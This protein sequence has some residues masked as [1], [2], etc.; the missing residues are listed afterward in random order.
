MVGAVDIGGT[1]IAV[2]LVDELGQIAAKQEFP[3]SVDRGFEFAMARV[4]EALKAQIASTH[5]QLEGIGMG[6]TGPVDPISGVLGN[7]NLLPGW[8]EMN[9][10]ELLSREFDISTAIENDADAVAIG[11]AM[12]GVGKG[13]QSLVCITVGTGIGSG[14]IIHGDVYRGVRGN[15]PELGHQIIEPAGPLCTCGLH[16][17]WESLASGTAMALWMQTEYPSAH[18]EK[19]LTAKE[20]CNLAQQGNGPA[21]RAVQR[22]ARYLG[23]GIV[24]VIT[25]F[26]PE[27]V[28]LGGSV[29]KSANLFLPQIRDAISSGCQIVPGHLCEVSLASLGDD[30]GLIGAAQVWYH[31]F[32]KSRS[33]CEV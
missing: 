31:R 33:S 8:E 11:E 6:C 5:C 18:S 9:P 26:L 25:C 24:N 27:V 1:K 22:E 29:M 2:G 20:I 32:Q 23:I 3:T 17:C 14:V 15:H 13:K 30:A 4:A 16:G 10:V 7:V 12:C 19:H 21:M 28:L